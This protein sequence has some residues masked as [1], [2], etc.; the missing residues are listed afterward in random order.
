MT[1]VVEALGWAAGT[2][3]AAAA[4]RCV[5]LSPLSLY[6]WLDEAVMTIMRRRY[7]TRF[8]VLVGGP[9]Q[10]DMCAQWATDKDRIFDLGE[11][12]RQALAAAGPADADSVFAEARRLEAAHGVVY[13]RD[14]VQQDRAIYGAYLAYAA[15]P[16]A[17]SRPPALADIYR[18][19]NGYFR[20]F[21]QLY[22]AHRV[23]LVIGRPG[24][25]LNTTSI[26]LALAIG[27][28]VTMPRH[29]RQRSDVM[30]SFGPYSNPHLLARTYQRLADQPLVP[31]DE[32]RPPT[33]SQRT[34]SWFQWRYT[35]RGVA[36]ELLVL[37]HTY[38]VKYARGLRHDGRLPAMQPFHRAAGAVLSSARLARW[39]ARSA[40]GDLDRLA[41]VPFL[42][43]PLP[44]EPEYT[45]QSLARHFS[46]VQA[47]A[48]QLALS[49]P[50]GF[51]L[52]IKEHSRLGD[53]RRQFYQDLLK[54]PN[55]AMADPNIPG[56]ELAARARAVATIAGTA[57]FE[58]L[59]LGKRAIVFATDVEY[60][61]LP[62]VARVT[63]FADLPAVVSEALREVDDAEALAIRQSA[64][65]LRRAYA[66]LAFDASGTRAF[67]GQTPLA[68][69]QAERAVDLLVATCLAERDYLARGGKL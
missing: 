68:P 66:E 67:G 12:E 43:F 53:R 34:F 69:A 49:L 19:I 22:Q 48:E 30:W 8:L 16:L 7:G 28:P 38:A 26:V 15:G 37:A 32:V 20:L 9:R 11:I 57:A 25:L 51:R 18:R 2:E 21:Q 3:V 61:F 29:A 58:A 56:V 23:D 6:D 5:F 46:N 44:K 41:A 24:N 39:M 33:S 55:V 17:N 31:L 35:A 1:T 14:I 62:A 36:K 13:L 64:A 42:F 52:V 60:G 54:L 10:R 45:V 50:A 40:D 65:R 47:M 59:L 63:S 27:L 4:P